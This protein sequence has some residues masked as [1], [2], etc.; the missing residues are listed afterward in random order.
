M[1]EIIEMK[2]VVVGVGKGKL[3]LFFVNIF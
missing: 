1:Q 3:N 2:Y